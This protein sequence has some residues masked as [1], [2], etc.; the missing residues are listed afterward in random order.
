MHDIGDVPKFAFIDNETP[1]AI[2][3]NATK[4]NEYL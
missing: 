2:M 3:N 4:S 1:N